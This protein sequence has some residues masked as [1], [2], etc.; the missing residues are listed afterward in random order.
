MSE[1]GCE[2]DKA[3]IVRFLT[4]VGDGERLGLIFRLAEEGEVRA[5]DLAEGSRLTRP[6]V[7]HHLKVLR[8]AN[9]V[10][11]HKQGKEILYRF[12]HEYVKEQLG[13]LLS[14]IEESREKL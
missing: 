2:L 11:A 7:S 12:N 1:N 10:L 8:D 13:G 5:G 14:A 9:V 6:A 3:A 4:A